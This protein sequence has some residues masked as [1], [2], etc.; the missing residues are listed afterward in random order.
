MSGNSDEDKRVSVQLTSLST[1]L[2]ESIEKQSSLEDKLRQSRKIIEEQKTT[3]TQYNELRIKYDQLDKNFSKKKVDLQ[4]LEQQL[5]AE[6]LGKAEAER[7]VDELNKEVEELTASLFD[8]ANNMV[9][10]ARKETDSIETK[11]KKLTEQLLEKDTILETLN[12]QLKN[13]KTV[14]QDL[15]T[16]SSMSII[17]NGNISLKGDVPLS[18]ENGGS[19]SHSLKKMS[20]TTSFQSQQE[21]VN[22]AIF[23]PKITNIRYDTFLY[24]EFLKFVAVLPHCNSIKNTSAESKLLRR[25]ISDEIHPVL[26]L[27]TSNGLGWL[28]KRTLMNQ[29]VEGLVVIEPLSGINETYRQSALYEVSISKSSIKSDQITKAKMFNFPAD[30]P[31]IAVRDP[32]A[33]CDES[34]SDCIGHARMY[35]LKTQTRNDDDTLSIT[36][37]YPLCQACLIKVRQ[38]CDIF[39][40]LR[41]LKSGVWQLEKVTLSTISKG[42]TSSFLKVAE[43]QFKQNEKATAQEKKQKRK[44]IISSLGKSHSS[45]VNAKLDCTVEP[46]GLPSTNIQRAW[47]Q[48]CKLRS[49][50]HWSHIGISNT[51]DC[52][53]STFAPVATNNKVV[54]DKLEP[55]LSGTS[56]TNGSFIPQRDNNASEESFLSIPE[57]IDNDDDIFDFENEGNTTGNIE[58]GNTT[59]EDR[60]EEN[61]TANLTDELD[62]ANVRDIVDSTD[63]VEAVDDIEA[64]DEIGATDET[65][66]TVEDDI[67]S[68]GDLVKIIDENTITHVNKEKLHI[69]EENL[70][71]EVIDSS[72]AKNTNKKS[73]KHKDFR[74]SILNDLDALEEQFESGLKLNNSNENVNTTK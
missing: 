16:E 57:D 54:A 52:V 25:L 12:L 41:S 74:K 32:C 6:K 44:S 8:E 5:Q 9:A 47:L 1:Q 15:Q 35:M 64:T 72:P 27:D 73:N 53:T 2:L 63:G 66:A 58:N 68:V 67:L 45:Y 51:E 4:R 37:Q 21:V 26:R 34:R 46:V 50:L 55:S 56:G 13:L 33:F 22:Y 19:S 18:N 14:L 24:N 31:P 23:T 65:E 70:N 28:T 59:L 39:A 48:L 17:N 3:I 43:N 49:I 71:L 20:T 42:D 10:D 38:T 29:I 60:K 61:E 7:K 69:V 62:T 40:F 11:N 30:S 36:N